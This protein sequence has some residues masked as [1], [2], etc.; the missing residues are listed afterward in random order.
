LTSAAGAETVVRDQLEG[1]VPEDVKA[2]LEAGA[3]A[4]YQLVVSLLDA[5]RRNG[6]DEVGLSTLPSRSGP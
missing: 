1:L 6:V 3:D 5:L 2:T 4:P